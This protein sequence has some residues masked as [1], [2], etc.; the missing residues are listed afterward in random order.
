MT[1][2]FTTSPIPP[3]F[4]F[5]YP[6]RCQGPSVVSVVPLCLKPLSL[7]NTNT[8]RRSTGMRTQLDKTH[9]L[10][11][12]HRRALAHVLPTYFQPAVDK[13]PEFR[14]MNRFSEIVDKIVPSICA[15]PFAISNLQFPPFPCFPASPPPFIPRPHLSCFLRSLRFLLFQSLPLVS[16][17]FLLSWLPYKSPDRLRSRGPGGHRCRSGPLR[18]VGRGGPLRWSRVFV[19]TA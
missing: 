4:V 11:V 2:P 12:T 1:R 14:P 13:T 3:Y 8:Q 15:L 19:V 10:F 9:L 18:M 7:P 16:L 5:S 6:R 17:G